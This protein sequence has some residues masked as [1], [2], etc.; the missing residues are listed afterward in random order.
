[1]KYLS[2]VFHKRFPRSLFHLLQLLWVTAAS[3]TA[4]PSNA[5]YVQVY[6]TI[7]KGALTFTGNTLE[8]GG[9]ASGSGT[10]GTAGTGGAFIAANSPTSKF[11]SFPL[12]TT[13]TWP[14]NA[15]AAVLSIPPGAKVLYAELIWSGTIG[16]GTVGTTQLSATQLNSTVSF[17]TPSG[18]SYTLTPNPATAGNSGTYYTRSTN[19]TGYVQ[20][21]GAGTYT[22][23]GV[24]AGTVAGST[25]DAAGWTLAVAYS[26]TS[27]PARNLT[28]FVGAEQANAAAA[29]VSGFCTPVSGPVNG[30]LLVSGVEGD[31]SGT[32]DTMLFGPTS[33]LS[34]TNNRLFGSNNPIGN[35]FASQINGDLG[36]LV[37]T[38][39]FGTTN[40][41]PGS[42]LAGARQGY[43]ITNVDASPQLGN[44]QTT[45]FAQGTTV[46]DNYAINA[47]GL[48]INVTSP[49][50][51]VTVKT[52]NKSS[53]FVGD[54]LRYSVNL[55][56]TAGNGAAT[57]V[58]FFDSIPSGMVLV[59]NSVTLNGTVQPGADPVAG[60]S[61]GNVPVGSIVTVAFDVSVVSLPASP[62]AAKFDNSARWTYTYIACAG[63]VAQTG[64]L[65]TAAISTSAARIE[66]VKTVSPT[67]QLVGGQQ[68]TYTISMPNTGLLN[69]SSTTLADPIPAGTV[70][71]AGS[72]KL[73]GS[74]VADLPGGVMPFATAALVNSPGQ[75][76]GV[77][78]VGAVATVQFGVAA[79]SAGTVVNKASID[80]DGSGPG[81]A[82]TVTAV[83]SGLTGP[84]VSKGFTPSTMAAGGT[85]SVVVTL[86]NPNATAITG[87]SVVDNLPSGMTIANPA[88]AATTCAGGTVAATVA[89]TT[90]GL[91][92]ST[93]PANGSC[94]FSAVVT[95]AVAGT[96][97]N[98]IPASAVTSSNA[99][100]NTAGSGT[101]TVTAPP[102]IAKSFTPG[103]VAP[104]TA[105][106]LSIQ[107]SNPTA[108][109]MT[110]VAFADIFPTTAAGAPGNMTL[111]DTVTANN[112]G[113][114]LTDS[115]GAALAAGS[116]G[117]KLVGGSIP[118]NNICV[119]TVNVK[120]PVGGA[121]SNAIPVGALST[122]G[123]ANTAAAV[124]TLQIASP[125]VSK[126]FST[127][128]TAVNTP[129]LMTV[130]LTN[131]TG[132]PI[133]A[134][135]FSDTYPVGLVNANTTV[136][137]TC[138]GTAV[139]SATA[140]NPGT[141][142]L[143]GATLAAG[144]S[145]TVQASVQSATAG[146]YINTIAAG[147]VTSSIG[148]NAAA[149][150][151]TLNVARPNISKAFS[152]KTMPLNGTTT[153]TITLSNPTSVAMTGAAFTDTLPSGL[154]ASVPAG[155]CVG[156]KAAS[157][158]TVSLSAG[159]IPAN[160]SC[161]VVATIT[162][163]SIGLKINSIPVAGLTVTGPTAASN[164]TAALDNISVLAAPTISKLFQTSP[165]LPG[166]GTTT[167]VITLFNSNSVALT[168]AT[169][170]DTFP[171][172]PGAMTVADLNTT[173][174]CTGTLQNNLATA[175]AAG[176]AGI[177][178]T[179]GTIPSNGSC[180]I[181]VNVKATVAGD[182]TN[183]IPATPATGFLNTLEGGGNT[184]A[185]SAALA[186]RLAAPTLTKSFN[187]S[188]IVANT[189][190][191]MT[192]V[193]TNP[194]TST[195][196]TG[197]SLSD[198]FPAG[199]KVFTTPNFSNT[200]GGT[201]SSGNVAGDGSFGISAATVPFNAGG[202]GSCSLVF[203]VTSSI[204]AAS[205]GMRNTTGVVN[206]T[207]ANS[208]LNA[209]ADLIVTA[210]PL[211]VPT[212]TKAFGP[213]TIT[214]GGT[215]TITF[216]LG[217]ANTGILS[218]A[219][220]TDTLTNMTA[221]SAAIG[222][223]CVGVSNSPA[224]SVGATA[225][226]LT[227]PNLAPG[228][229]TVA[230]LVTSSNLGANPNT[231]SGVSTTETPTAG[232]GSGPV[233]LTVVAGIFLTVTKVANTSTVVNTSSGTTASYSVTV[234]NSSSSG[235]TGVKLIDNLPAGFT[236][237]TTTNATLD[238]A[239]L[240]SSSYTVTGITTPQWD[241]APVSGGFTI[242][243]GKT[244]VF[245]FIA[246]VT[247]TVADGVYN[248]SASATSS[249]ATSITN[250]DGAANTSDNV[251]VTSAII[252]ASKTTS[253]PVVANSP[254]GATASYTITINNTGSAQATGVKVT[255][256]LPAGFSYASTSSVVAN[257]STTAF[258]TGGTTAVPQWDSSPP[259][260][261][262][263]NPG[264]GL[265]ITFNAFITST[266]IDGVYNNSVATTGVV[267]NA[268]NYVGSGNSPEAVT[269][270][271]Q[272][273]LTLGKSHTGSFT[274][275][276]NG[277][278]NL[279]VKNI[280]TSPT[281]GTITIVDTLPTGLAFVSNDN[282]SIWTCA[283]AG[284][285]VTCNTP[286]T[287][288]LASNSTSSV[289]LT[290]SVTAAG[291]VVNS[292]VV[293]GG[294]AVLP[295]TPTQDPTTIDS[296]VTGVSLFG[297]VYSDANHNLQKD[298]AEAG[299]GL[300]LFAK[301]VPST[302][303][304]GP[305]LQ[306]VAVSAVT[307]AYQ[308]TQVPAGNYTIVI[309]DNSTLSDVLPTISSSWMGTEMPDQQ[310]SN[311]AVAAV[312][313]QNLN[314]G[315]FYGNKLSGRVF[316]DNG[317]GAGGVANNGN[318]D[319]GELGLPTVMVKL[320]DSTG[321]TTIDSVRTDGGGSYSLW[322]PAAQS[323]ST[324]KVVEVNL[325]GYLSTG[326][327]SAAGLVYDRAADAFSVNYSAGTSYTGVNFGDVPPNTL[328]GNNQQ[329]NLP[330]NP[331]FYPH[332]FTA[333]TAGSVTFSTISPAGWPQIVYV[334]TNC[335]GAI[336][337]G[338]PVASGSSS[339]LANQKVCLILRETIPSGTPFNAQDS[340][341]LLASF[342]YTNA[343]PALVVT[344]TN[345]DL[346][347]VG[348]PG[349][350]ALVLFKSQD[351]ATPSSGSVINYVISFTNN[352]SG[353]LS[354][355]RVTDQT[356]AYTT[357]L[358]AVCPAS[359][360]AALTAC[361]ITKPLVGQTGA[362]EWNLTGSLLP[363][364]SGQVGFSVKLD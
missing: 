320:T 277:V 213:S 341:T 89:G 188:T 151:A 196:I 170:I 331:V 184:V 65:I 105:S 16:T 342:S 231:V 58:V 162:G 40:S 66:P 163:T 155:T 38:G 138:G 194:S 212:I 275:G 244:L 353:S 61:I 321:S 79:T 119:V 39:S 110:A 211:S 255:D 338:E 316:V 102:S 11:G 202:T 270:S 2:A 350:A 37:T 282:T 92:G 261:F 207:N 169:F 44:S 120:A 57:S 222:G 161:T 97:V 218:N 186:V 45:A 131:I 356:P 289:N 228:G 160:G 358:S 274:V 141:L 339:V 96:Y 246:S 216:T 312:D 348:A 90:L 142:V 81:T 268:V 191:T 189:P 24:P 243:A 107:L 23:G 220:F 203:Q 94:S 76:P 144:A 50:F 106:S 115:A 153:L 197:A 70:Y 234:T 315:L 93:I 346:T 54:T 325:S 219:N 49:V 48:Q 1:M 150:N 265:V 56:N 272:A 223:T 18:A 205:P 326:G 187:P 319:G 308:F 192:L 124:G 327:S 225:L 173:N 190:T 214:A 239:Q 135:A 3:L 298:S 176:S 182:Y 156:T 111:F 168:S 287:F 85:S 235:A 362:I 313:L 271:S 171:I 86:T 174:S 355:L 337:A 68:A 181:T 12:G 35:F 229:C 42:N 128:F 352:G 208:S 251:T 172:A 30:R 41:T 335:N 343:S 15:S 104:N 295:A 7:Q 233:N 307:G 210:P 123:G 336:D 9:S 95:V 332:T 43:D 232:A 117:I 364:G 62:A 340:A 20:L 199:M 249:N 262:T 309:D 248:N 245:S 361:T 206:S 33:P 328:T 167:L 283:A 269:I 112:C 71:V 152:A 304:S 254:G 285:I 8:L 215:S 64:E 200:C 349:G 302:S 17:K 80:P 101:L 98:N 201:V 149:A 46:G 242:P 21:A 145:C 305:A 360:P 357:F 279:I 72:T 310:R 253:T 134:L 148:A 88:N 118:A 260:G 240:P 82:I 14:N 230:I 183:S 19:V 77:I 125:Q 113:G 323:G 276:T 126:A 290:V 344:M 318:L 127:A 140:S 263:I 133:T 69:T 100:V 122:S 193:I 237:L 209:S 241:T 278:Y 217:S 333:G 25:I 103:T 32:G 303:P 293:S 52:A 154:I 75:S 158:S 136:A 139:A 178:L 74:A 67:G 273:V 180:V 130:T 317:T 159:I 47:L 314:F 252:A 28:I 250:F 4:L 143:T 264:A 351:N 175:L 60:I 5:A 198:I 291:S 63:A 121:Y 157:G 6:S 27:Q 297:F 51:P 83:N 238:G 108:S 165:I 266:V 53:T 258:T 281:A 73:N 347:T 345:T 185:A 164:G 288:L 166:T 114:V 224:L 354:T 78:A 257:G 109:T 221:A 146:T 296:L 247:S 284:Q 55:D 10:P 334:D 286:L 226:N 195:A 31:S 330:G 204:I 22:M 329:S 34:T 137:N 29:S 84:G 259:G 177:K 179:G 294:S 322:I 292:A 267:K 129:V 301:L 299:T 87:A 324:L 26:D 227:V 99:G 13:S 147:S 116:V 363:A 300:T 359:L 236:Y 256:T 91:S 36:T 132:S 311:V 306:A 59:P 280:G